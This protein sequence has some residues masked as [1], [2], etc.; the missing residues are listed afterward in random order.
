MNNYKFISDY[1]NINKYRLSFNELA[2]NTFGVDFEK[3]YQ[4]GFWNDSYLC[5]SYVDQD[6][7]VANVSI[8]KLNIILD[9]KEFK[10]LQVGT[11]MTHP[12]YRNMGLSKSLM[13]IMLK[14]LEPNFDFVYLFANK[15]VLDFY[16]KFGFKKAEQYRF[17]SEI[18]IKSNYEKAKMLDINNEEDRKIIKRLSRERIP[19]SQIC[20]V[21]NGEAILGW[22]CVNV[23]NE[24]I[25]YLKEDDVIVI[26][27]TENEVL[28]LYDIVSKNNIMISEILEK[29]SNFEIKRVVFYYTPDYFDFQITKE[30]HEDSNDTLFMKP[31]LNVTK[32]FVFP[33]TA[34]A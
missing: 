15:S 27:K 33:L 31:L 14:E 2:N 30:A 34:H 16:P 29:I 21:K 10:G 23:F 12:D 26:F 11:V 18:K 28:H 19:I 5:Y 8:S 4:Y 6:N 17:S 25:F 7:V 32:D 22:Y 20:S 3:W 1:K 9:K 24:N 13:E